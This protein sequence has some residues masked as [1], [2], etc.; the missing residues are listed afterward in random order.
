MGRRDHLH[1]VWSWVSWFLVC[2]INQN[3]LDRFDRQ[4][5]HD[6]GRRREEHVL[7]KTSSVYSKSS[8]NGIM[9]LVV[10]RYGSVQVA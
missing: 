10:A 1:G 8:I 4:W 9:A 5:F 6:R 3:A 2:H 7:F